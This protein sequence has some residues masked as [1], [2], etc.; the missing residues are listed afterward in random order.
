[1]LIRVFAGIGA[2]HNQPPI[3]PISFDNKFVHLSSPPTRTD[4]S[5][6]PPTILPPPRARNQYL[7]LIVHG[8]REDGLDLRVWG[9][10]RWGEVRFAIRKLWLENSQN[11]QQS[12]IQLTILAIVPTGCWTLGDDPQTACVHS[13]Q[14]KAT[15]QKHGRHEHRR[16]ALV[17]IVSWGGSTDGVP[18]L[19]GGQ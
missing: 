18:L 11:K 4:L 9:A 17:G 16:F 12:T 3:A 7:R 5:C 2:H 10:Q 13:W 14:Q 19:H 15:M 1:L 8:R 6:N